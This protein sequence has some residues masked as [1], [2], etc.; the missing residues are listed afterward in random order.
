MV[1]TA[2]RYRSQAIG[3]LYGHLQGASVALDASKS[4]LGSALPSGLQWELMRAVVL[5]G[6]RYPAACGLPLPPTPDER[7]EARLAVALEAVRERLK[8]AKHEK[9]AVGCDT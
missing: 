4:R 8:E 6:Q 7:E 1:S 5:V 9:G 2:A 3:E